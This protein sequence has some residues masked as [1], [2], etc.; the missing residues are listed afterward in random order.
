MD[1]VGPDHVGLG[2]DWDGFSEPYFEG[3]RHV[4]DEPNLIATLMSAG[5]DEESLA[6]IV[7][8]NMRRVLTENLPN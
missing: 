7:G 2:S 8:G 3:L 5:Y 4:G 1:L 6:K